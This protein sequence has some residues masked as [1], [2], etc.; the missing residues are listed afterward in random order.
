MRGR[1]LFSV[2]CL[3]VATL[4]CADE[5]VDAS[6][7][8]GKF[9]CGYQGWF[10]TPGDGSNMGWNHYSRVRHEI[11]RDT[12]VV[13]MWPDVSDFDEK[14]KVSVPGFLHPDGSQAY[15]ISGHNPNVIDKHFEWM[16]QYD[17]D[18]VWY[19]H[20]LVGFENGKDALG[21]ES[22]RQNMIWVKDSAKKHGRVWAVCFDT[23]NIESAEIPAQVI[24]EWKRI[25]DAEIINGDEYLHENGHPV[26][27][28]WGLFHNEQSNRLEP[29]EAKIIM[30]FFA[31]E[32]KYKATLVMGGNWNWAKTP[33]DWKATF[34]SFKYFT[35]W[36]VNNLA[37]R[38]DG[39]KGASMGFWP[40][41]LKR[42]QANGTFWIPVVYPGFSWNNLYQQPEGQTTS[43]RKK[44]DFLW[45]QFY[46]AA[47]LGIDTFYIAMFDE[48]DE[49]TAVFKICP[50][51]PLNAKLL[52]TEGMPADWY[53]RLIKEAK[54]IIKSQKPFPRDIP[55]QP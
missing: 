22:R 44:G 18:G 55:I 42:A 8:K 27:H 31:T 36:N 15:V 4:S 28:V 6:T 14:D 33:D 34:A 24:T 10:R 48:I 23:A 5:K 43:P 45:E 26:V 46:E 39:S 11:D 20:F 32:G 25:V 29:K 16:K 2:V 47:N 7:L 1:F 30:D 19:Q 9:M 3:I 35:P 52:D 49:G 50:N 37:P 41:D 38:S 13:D 17:I 53:L 40:E 54:H 51:P 12:L 21:Y